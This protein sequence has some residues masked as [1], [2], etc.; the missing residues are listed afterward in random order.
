MVEQPVVVD[1]K[2]IAEQMT[3]KYLLQQ[4]CTVSINSSSQMI[5]IALVALADA[6]QKYKYIH[7]DLPGDGFIIC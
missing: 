5:T 7:K 2:Q 6:S 4:T 1:L 3:H